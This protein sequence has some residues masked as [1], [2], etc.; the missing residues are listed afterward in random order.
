MRALRVTRDVA[1][2]QLVDV[3]EP[4]PGPGEVLIRITAAGLCGTDVACAFRPQD[5]LTRKGTTTLGHEPAGTVWG[6]GPGVDGW[7]PGDRVA[8][9]SIVSCGSCSLC[10]RGMSEICSRAS[11]IGMHHDGAVAE[12]M[13][14]PVGNLVRLPDSVPDTAAA[15]LTDAVAT[16][17]H[18]L[19]ER[20]GLRPGEAVAI[21]GIGGLGQHAVQLARAFGAGTLIAV[22]TRAD[23]LV[24][25]KAL[26]ADHTFDA[27]D[28]R[29][30]DLVREVNGGS[31]VD[32]AGVFVGSSSAI[33]AAFGTVAKGG[34]LVVVG[35]SESDVVLPPSGA[36]ARREVSL[37]GS[38]GFRMD[39]L[40]RLV[41]L[42]AERRL[43]LS[44]SVSHEFSLEDS[45]A[46]LELLH[47]GAESVRRVLV[48]PAAGR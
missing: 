16:P 44:E 30:P 14:A 41:D 28:P 48:R 33:R 42:V 40:E 27:N 29:L 39:E 13:T 19:F 21:F 11:I 47:A 12:L 4:A 23:Q 7:R 32:L 26:G 8:V 1:G 38:G 9:N 24:H 43:D 5:R 3:P 22:D 31:G 18:A 2:A 45:P 17:F 20:G 25:A 34:R 15:I 46:A 37:I 35:L 10:R 36:L 6:L